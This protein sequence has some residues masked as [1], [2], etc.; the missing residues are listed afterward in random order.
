MYTELWEQVYESLTCHVADPWRMPG[1][2][3]A[4]SDNSYCM[5]QYRKMRD[6]YDR[7][8]DRLGVEDEDA[9]IE[10]IIACYMGIQRELC[11]LMFTY[12]RQFPT[13]D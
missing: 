11:H 9:D 3:N 10:I 13:D 8:C 2:I 6:A 1:V 5:G 7:L 12:G 4:F